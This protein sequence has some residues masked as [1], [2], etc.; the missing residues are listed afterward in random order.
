[1][2]GNPNSSFS[3][4]YTDFLSDARFVHFGREGMLQELAQVISVPNPDHRDLHGL[5]G[6]GKTSLLRYLAGIP[7]TDGRFI[8]HYREYLNG[9]YK[10]HP[11]RLFFLYLSGWIDSIHPFVLMARELNSRLREYVAAATEK[12]DIDGALLAPLTVGDD[13]RAEAFDI[14]E[15]TV[16]ALSLA[17][18]RPVLLFDNFDTELGFGK[19][20]VDEVGRLGSVREY[21]S[22][23]FAT[24]RLLEEVNPAAKGSPLFKQLTQMPFRNMH[25]D[26]AAQFLRAPLELAKVDL[27]AAD[28]DHLIELAGGF[29]YLLLLAGRAL[30]DLRRHLGLH[31]KPAEPLSESMLLYLDERLRQEFWRPFEHSFQNLNAHQ[32]A[33]LID[34]A[35]RETISLDSLLKAG[36]QSSRL[37]WLEQYGLIDV[38]PDGRL[39]LFSRL[40][41]EFVLGQAKA[42]AAQA[43]PSLA[44]TDLTVQQETL[45]NVFRN[46]PDEVVT[47]EEL[48]RMLWGWPSSRRA[49]DI[50]KGDLD[51][52]RIAVS[53][54][55]RELEK[56]QTGESIVSLRSRGYR[57]EPAR[58]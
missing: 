46:R 23:I 54:L 7:S 6:M 18:I 20:D 47:F 30:W 11:E 2:Y 25:D 9:E 55:R 22:L 31:D 50:Q 8:E 35:R 57:F 21:G 28:I 43:T 27:P 37:S 34:L 3:N 42:Q 13:E 32:Q 45:Y 53:K 14:L 44:S 1:M 17:G 19:L 52:I 10:Q 29:R 4:P 38:L 40:F 58:G 36:N 39:R 49:K 51:K 12:P 41:Q 24:E 48:G 33:V 56:S 16:R 15:T 26:Q 5:S